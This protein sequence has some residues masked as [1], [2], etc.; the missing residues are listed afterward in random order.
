[1]IIVL[2]YTLVNNSAHSSISCMSDAWAIVAVLRL[3]I[4]ETTY[5]WG[6]GVSTMIEAI[7]MEPTQL[8]AGKKI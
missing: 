3:Q 8:C 1:M 5:S 6:G 4:D 2:N 7:I